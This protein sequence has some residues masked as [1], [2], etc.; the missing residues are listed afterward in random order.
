[1]ETESVEKNADK[2]FLEVTDKHLTST[3]QD[4]EDNESKLSEQ[5]I[6]PVKMDAV[7]ED[8]DVESFQG[9]ELVH[10]Q[11]PRSLKG[12]VTLFSGVIIFLDF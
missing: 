12:I 6:E 1:M 2:E 8:V 3:V 5:K 9:I 11:S 10:D 4:D 7:D